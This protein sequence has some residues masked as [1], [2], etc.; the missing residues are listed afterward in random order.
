MM[1]YGTVVTDSCRGSV[2]EVKDPMSSRGATMTHGRTIGETREGL[3]I[4]I[5][6]RR[7]QSFRWWNVMFFPLHRRI[8]ELKLKHQV[9]EGLT[10][11]SEDMLNRFHRLDALDLGAL[12]D[13]KTQLLISWGFDID[14]SQVEWDAIFYHLAG[15]NSGLAKEAAVLGWVNS[16]LARKA[17]TP[18]TLVTLV[19]YWETTLRNI[20]HALL[21]SHFIIY[22][23]SSFA[24]MWRFI[25][26]FAALYMFLSVPYMIF[27]LREDLYTRYF[28]SLIISWV[29][30][31]VLL[32]DLIFNFNQS[33]VDER[34]KEV[35]SCM[36]A[37][38]SQSLF[39]S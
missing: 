12:D 37:C 30:D 8:A 24:R 13:T 3:P 26:T 18:S 9:D 5:P 14:L 10:A 7:Y 19:R 23:K 1:L 16:L 39:L 34:S 17:R 32:L 6:S 28:T 2:N 27:I 35:C 22:H 33:F 36:H 38:R 29:F 25:K 21:T 4:A 11:S 20:F 31:L 15:P